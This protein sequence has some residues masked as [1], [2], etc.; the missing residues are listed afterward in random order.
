VTKAELKAARTDVENHVPYGDAAVDEHLA[1]TEG[2]SRGPPRRLR[3]PLVPVALSHLPDPKV[4]KEFGVRQVR[5]DAILC[6]KIKSQQGA[7]LSVRCEF[8][9]LGHG[10]RAVM[11]G[12]RPPQRPIVRANLVD[13]GN[14]VAVINI[15]A[16]RYRR[17]AGLDFADRDRHLFGQEY[18]FEFPAPRELVLLP[19]VHRNRDEMILHERNSVLDDWGESMIAGGRRP[20]TPV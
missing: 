12:Q 19:V 13:T 2:D 11:A 14:T 17:G 20:V 7:D 16:I 1:I 18:A 3:E 4:R 9:K 8:E 6:D 5:S 15:N 10:D